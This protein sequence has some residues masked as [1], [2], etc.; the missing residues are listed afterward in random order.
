MDAVL[1]R[2]NLLEERINRLVTALA[3]ERKRGGPRVEENETLKAQISREKQKTAQL[4]EKIT[5]LRR[6]D[7]EQKQ[8]YDI[9]KKRLEKLL[10]ELDEIPDQ[11]SA[12]PDT[13]DGPDA[14]DAKSGVLEEGEIEEI[15]L[16]DEIDPMDDPEDEETADEEEAE[17]DLAAEDG[18]EPPD[19]TPDADLT[20]PIPD[21]EEPAGEDKEEEEPELFA[22]PPKAPRGRPPKNTDDDL[23]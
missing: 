3:E 8:S 7:A 20:D 4:E 1:E 23:I 9:L 17:L 12:E 13:D 2:L 21:F 15:D 18:A 22:G 5:V 14:Q 6:E 16:D 10:K 19:D 11:I